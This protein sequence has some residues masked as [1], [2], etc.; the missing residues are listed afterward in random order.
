MTLSQE[1]TYL[2]FNTY[3]MVLVLYTVYFLLRIFTENIAKQV[4]IGATMLLITNSVLYLIYSVRNKNVVN[5]VMS[6]IMMAVGLFLFYYYIAYIMNKPKPIPKIRKG[7]RYITE[8]EQW[9]EKNMKNP[10]FE[11]Q[12]AEK[13]KMDKRFG[14]DWIYPEG[15]I[16]S[17][18]KLKQKIREIRV[19][20]LRDERTLDKMIADLE[21]IAE[22]RSKP[23]KQRT[24]ELNTLRSEDPTFAQQVIQA[25]KSE[26]P[27]QP[28]SQT[29]LKTILQEPILEQPLNNMLTMLGKSVKNDQELQAQFFEKLGSDLVATRAKLIKQKKPFLP[30][31]FHDKFL[32]EIKGK[33]PSIWLHRTANSENMTDKQLLDVYT[34][35]I[36]SDIRSEQKDRAR[37]VASS[38]RRRY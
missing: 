36:L 24:K 21:K 35:K 15:S 10:D 2:F 26:M 30:D 31:Q 5:I 3:I 1:Y 16:L 17:P 22:L 37:K 6:S 9:I 23:S 25:V 14:Q 19:S 33:D 27:Q 29:V 8:A 13:L 12:L 20:K 4:F 28:K 34:S 32:S 18:Q 38:R 7:L 11:K